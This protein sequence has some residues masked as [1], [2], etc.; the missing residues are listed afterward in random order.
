MISC[1][2]IQVT[3]VVDAAVMNSKWLHPE[4]IMAWLIVYDEINCP[5]TEIHSKAIDF[6]VNF[7]LL[8]P[9]FSGCALNLD[10]Q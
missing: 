5:L 7:A 2:L 6:N 10:Y 3:R 4:S 9:L 1:D 8:P